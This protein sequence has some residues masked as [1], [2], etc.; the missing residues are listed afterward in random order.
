MEHRLPENHNC[1][2]APER[3]PLGSWEAK[4]R[5][6]EQQEKTAKQKSSMVS[7]G[8][9]HFVR[10]E[11]P[12]LDLRKREKESKFRFPKRRKKMLSHE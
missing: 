5:I 2:E 10:K 9:F 4:Q 1:Q 12:T 6:A 3:V 7:E 11:L 8:D